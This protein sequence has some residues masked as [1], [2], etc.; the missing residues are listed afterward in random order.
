MSLSLFI[1]IVG[2]VL[3]GAIGTYISGNIYD[4]YNKKKPTQIQPPE[5]YDTIIKDVKTFEEI[6]NSQVNEHKNNQSVKNNYD[7]DNNKHGNIFNN[8][9]EKTEDIY[10]NDALYDC[11]FYDFYSIIGR[12]KE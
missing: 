1:R 9:I 3:G 2:G 5:K 4:Y 10:I 8:N 12:D 6:L 11:T 7:C